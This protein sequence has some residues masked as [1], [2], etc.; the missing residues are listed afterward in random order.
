MF[1]VNLVNAYKKKACTTAWHDLHCFQYLTVHAVAE[2]TQSYY[3][4]HKW[5]KCRVVYRPAR[6]RKQYVLQRHFVSPVGLLTLTQCSIAWTAESRQLN[7]ESPH[8][9]KLSIFFESLAVQWPV[10]GDGETDRKVGGS[11]P[12]CRYK[13]QLHVS[14]DSRGQ[15][16]HLVYFFFL[17]L[18]LLSSSAFAC[19]DNANSD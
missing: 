16:I 17:L 2:I 13:L 9:L 7:I 12:V 5:V 4:P 15:R 1:S 11:M 6:S 3:V 8:T 18:S 14:C 19:N 10:N